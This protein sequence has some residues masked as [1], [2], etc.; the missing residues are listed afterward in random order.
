MILANTKFE[1]TIPAISRWAAARLAIYVV[2]GALTAAVFVS[3][4]AFYSYVWPARPLVQTPSPPQDSKSA[5]AVMDPP[6]NAI[7]QI[8]SPNAVEG[9]AMSRLSVPEMQ[10][11]SIIVVNKNAKSYSTIGSVIGSNQKPTAA[12]WTLEVVTLGSRI[13]NDFG[14]KTPDKF[15]LSARELHWYAVRSPQ[16]VTIYAVATEAE[17]SAAMAKAIK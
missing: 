2:V 15:Q 6:D 13:S 12:D 16:R 11:A 3:G 7:K 1:L 17:V 4:A 5:P 14:L 8:F 10:G 9:I